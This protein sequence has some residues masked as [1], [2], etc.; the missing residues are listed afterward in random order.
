MGIKTTI[1]CDRCEREIDD[2]DYTAIHGQVETDHN[3]MDMPDERSRFSGVYCLQCGLI[4]AGQ[5][6]EVMTKAA[7]IV[8]PA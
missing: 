6:D 3:R 5:L 8:L 7:Q 1:T 4:V 2:E